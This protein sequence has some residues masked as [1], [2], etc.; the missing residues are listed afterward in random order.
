MKE[1]FE[2][3]FDPKVGSDIYVVIVRYGT[4][5]TFSHCDG[6]WQKIGIYKTS[7]EAYKVKKSINNGKYVGYKN[8]EGYFESLQD[9]EIHTMTVEE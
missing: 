7:K 2:I 3:D 1:E 8:W 6:C 5:C 9:V 4:G